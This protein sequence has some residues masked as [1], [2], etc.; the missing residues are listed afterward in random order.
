[1]LRHLSRSL[2]CGLAV[3]LA[4]HGV[5]PQTCPDAAPRNKAAQ[6]AALPSCSRA[7]LKGHSKG[8]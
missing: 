2:L 6:R 1:M 4:S 3:V 7:I 5:K 8:I